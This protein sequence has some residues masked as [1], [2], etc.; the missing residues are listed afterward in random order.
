MVVDRR[1]AQ[2]LDDAIWRPRCEDA[3]GMTD[4]SRTRQD[5]TLHGSARY[6]EY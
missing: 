5:A 3:D 4:A 1:A 6:E 2:D